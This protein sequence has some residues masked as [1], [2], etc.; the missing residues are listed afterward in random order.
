MLRRAVVYVLAAAAFTSVAGGQQQP[1]PVRQLGPIERVSAQPLRSV[2]SARPLS[3][4]RVLVNNFLDRQVL[5]F[6]STLMTATVIVDLTRA[7]AGAYS[8]QQGALI[9]YRGDSSL[10]VDLGSSSML[11]I[12]P[13]GKI[14]RVIAVPRSGDLASLLTPMFGISGFDIRGRLVNRG[15]IRGTPTPSPVVGQ[16]PILV[17]PDSAPIVRVD[18]ATRAVDTAAFYKIELFTYRRTQR[19]NGSFSSQ[20]LRNPLPLTDAWAILPDGS[21]GVVRGRNYHI[22]WVNADG[23]RTSGPRMPFDWKHLNDDEKTAL[24]DSARLVAVARNDSV[25]AANRQQ[26]LAA[27]AAAG[28]PFPP[29]AA[30]PAPPLFIEP[31]DLPDYIHP[32]A[33]G[34][35]RADADGN[36]WIRTSKFVK[37][38]PVYDIVN[39]QGALIDRVQLPPFRTIAGFGPGVVY[40][41]VLDSAKVAHLERARVK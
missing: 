23:S 15:G 1:P 19:E 17:Q 25:A 37:G 33:E 32:F 35:A 39:R 3:D 30:T 9:A 31:K 5:L 11:V 41:G 36:I 7:A 16:P 8:G 27:A 24:I 38:Q 26:A 6:D 29:P 13:S 40:M 34:A 14:D 4:R 28:R 18:L 10:F 2:S 12:A 22:D 21:I 20:S